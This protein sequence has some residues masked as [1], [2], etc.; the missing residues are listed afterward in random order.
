MRPPVDPEVGV[1]KK[2]DDLWTKGSSRRP[3]SSHGWKAAPPRFPPRKTFKRI[4]LLLLVT[5]AVYLF[6]H[7][8]PTDLGPATSLRP[9]Y[10]HPSPNAPPRAVPRPNPPNTAGQS[11]GNKGAAAL[12][13]DYDGPI[14]FLELART[15]HA[16]DSTK[17][18]SAA[19]KNVLFAA[20]SLRSATILLPLACQMGKELRAYVHFALM[21]RSEIPL[22]ELRD[23]NGIDD[24]CQIIFHGMEPPSLAMG[25]ASLV[26]NSHH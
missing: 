23:V 12:T 17:G 3:A 5:T 21:S 13:R 8:I 18:A 24:S 9:V 4:G 2:D 10:T 22:Q 14:R 19:N 26:S 6:I 20:S 15:L 25:L 1:T 16:I 7:N 11:D